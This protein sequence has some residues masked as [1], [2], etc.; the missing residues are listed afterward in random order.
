MRFPARLRSAAAAVFFISLCAGADQLSKYWLA[1]HLSE[2][3]EYRLLPFL[4]LFHTRN[5]GIAFSMLS[6]FSDVGL[7]LLTVAIIGFVLWLEWQLPRG[8]R[9]ARFG[10]WLIIGGAVGNLI[11]RIRL[12]YVVDF[13]LFHLGSWSF[14]VFNLADAFITCGAVCVFI[15][16]IFHW[17]A[18]KKQK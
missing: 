1:A 11:D 10:Y 5:T 18:P 7:I 12:H 9:L 3:A 16:E 2:G 14:A 15:S 13:I 6:S 4:S 8:H 17:T